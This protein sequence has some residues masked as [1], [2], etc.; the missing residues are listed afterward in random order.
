MYCIVA[1]FID[2]FSPRDH[3]GS[4][5]WTYKSQRGYARENFARSNS[6]VTN[7]PDLFA[8]RIEHRKFEYLAQVNHN[9]SAQRQSRYTCLG[10][11]Y[12]L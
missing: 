9:V 7:A 2:V 1:E 5:T 3:E 11:G 6:K 4:M 10:L 12:K 8:I